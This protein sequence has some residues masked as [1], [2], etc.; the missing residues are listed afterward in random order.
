MDEE[1][2]K[3]YQTVL[4]LNLFIV[5]NLN[6][7]VISQILIILSIFLY[8]VSILLFT[9]VLLSDFLTSLIFIY[10]DSNL[11]RF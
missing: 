3:A 11:I 4:L 5:K 7:A 9:L 6:I 2:I 1:I 10:L 8:N